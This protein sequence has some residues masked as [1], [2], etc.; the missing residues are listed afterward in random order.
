MMEMLEGGEVNE[1][2]E[3][4]TSEELRD[5]LVAR[6]IVE[7]GFKPSVASILPGFDLGYKNDEGVEVIIYRVPE[8]SSI[9]VVFALSVWCRSGDHFRQS[10][11]DHMISEQFTVPSLEELEKAWPHFKEVIS[12][13]K[14]LVQ[15]HEPVA[16]EKPMTAADLA[17]LAGI[18]VTSWLIIYG[19][20]RAI[21]EVVKFIQD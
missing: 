8:S 4:L 21:Y 10:T 1:G 16:I 7:E 13:G 18:S 3:I 20:G 14:M 6:L 17:R 9:L 12:A 15:Y 19:V 5:M 2:G 11:F